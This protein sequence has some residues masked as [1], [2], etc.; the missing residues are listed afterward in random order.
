VC[1]FNGKV[2]FVVGVSFCK[3]CAFM[4]G[5]R[6][7]VLEESTLLLIEHIQN[8]SCMALSSCSA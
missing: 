6:N 7:A 3:L 2:M 1:G 5:F 8:V 4:F